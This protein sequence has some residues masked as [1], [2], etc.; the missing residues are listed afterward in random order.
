[1]NITVVNREFPTEPIASTA[2]AILHPL[3]GL[4]SRFLY[5]YLRSPVFITYVE[6]V[7]TGIAYP[8][9][10]DGQFFSGL[11]PLA[12]ISEQHRIVAKI[13]E[14][15]ALC[16]QL[17]AERN[18]R[19]T[20]HRQLIRAIHHPLTE[21]TDSTQTHRAWQRIRDHFN[22]LY[23]TP[24]AVQALR[25]TILQLAVQGKLVPQDPNDEPASELLKRIEAEKAKLVA[26][27][28]IR[29]PKPLPPISE[30]EKPFAL[31]EGWEWVIFGNV[32]IIERGGSPRPIKDYLT[33]ESSGLNWIKIGDS[34][35]GIT[36]TL[37]QLH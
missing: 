5:W 25:Q 32:A 19:D 24:E 8:A 3:C 31:P 22:P 11:F 28:K 2:F 13:D 7:Q 15:M 21:A 34:D 29:K 30:E 33:E 36:V 18:A 35:I 12:P 26:E 4:N 27:G 14:L 20:T 6:S 9:V 10:N 17:D 37:Y 1:M 16:D 23:T